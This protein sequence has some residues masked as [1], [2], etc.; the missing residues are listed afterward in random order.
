MKVNADFL[1]YLQ[2]KSY[3]SLR[4]DMAI[5]LKNFMESQQDRPLLRSQY[6]K[7]LIEYLKDH[8]PGKITERYL[9]F[10]GEK[11]ENEKGLFKGVS[12][13]LDPELK[14][15]IPIIIATSISR[16]ILIELGILSILLQSLIFVG[17]VI[18]LALV[19]G[20]FAVKELGWSPET[21]HEELIEELYPKFSKELEKNLEEELKK[22]QENQ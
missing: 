14:S 6:K 19:G 13:E 21:V 17:G 1:D 7:L 10:H 16:M 8:L 3:T 18:S 9:A 2:G 12:N 15:T 11:L 20:Y 5:L 22:R 4:E